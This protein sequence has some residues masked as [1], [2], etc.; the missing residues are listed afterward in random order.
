MKR[1]SIRLLTALLV[2]RCPVILAVA[3]ASAHGA[4]KQHIEPYFSGDIIAV[5][6]RIDQQ[7][8]Q[9]FLDTGA[10]ATAL[11]ATGASRLKIASEPAEPFTVAGT[12]VEGRRA[13][14]LDFEMF[15]QRAR[16]KLPILPWAHSYDGVL[17]WRN[18]NGTM[19]IDGIERRIHALQN[20]PARVGWQQWE[21]EPQNS[22]LF[23]SITR[24]GRPFG[25]VFI[26]TG[27][28]GGLRLA[29]K[30]WAEWIAKHPSKSRTIERFQYAVGEPMVNELA[31]ADEYQL[32]DLA[33]HSLDIGPIPTA[34]DDSALDKD[35]KEFIA[36][37]GTR[38][39]R[40]MR[41]ILS[42]ATNELW[43]QSIPEAPTHN[44]LG[45]VFLPQKEHNGALV[46]HVAHNSPAADAGLRDG[47][48]FVSVNDE[49]PHADTKI[50]SQRLDAIFSEPPG[51]AVTLRVRRSGA[52]ITIHA[53]LRNLLR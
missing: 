38:A 6:A 23:I 28:S 42:R 21:I 36:T 24:D 29:P 50:Q 10:S 20:L 19:L 9:W 34:K 11:F 27:V 33:F 3:M 26:D 53:T 48:Q 5:D 7:A 41:I 47:D 31:W 32:G 2:N 40:H 49:K 16:L 46:C 45:A 51:T 8:S 12:R 37:I 25:R 17:S 43:T 13:K 44:R 39:L 1:A 14:E 18:L 15:G 52:E 4:D 30:L 35:G 22:Q